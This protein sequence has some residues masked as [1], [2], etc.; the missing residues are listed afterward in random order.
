MRAVNVF[1]IFF[2]TSHTGAV[3]L[4]SAQENAICSWGIERGGVGC[5]VWGGG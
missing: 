4:K 1:S 2:L 3:L 5:G